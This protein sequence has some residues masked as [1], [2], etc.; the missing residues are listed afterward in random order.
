ME[1]QIPRERL[2][3]LVK[4]VERNLNQPNVV[5]VTL[6]F[7]AYLEAIAD[8]ITEQ[9]LPSASGWNHAKKL[10]VLRDYPLLDEP[11]FL[12]ACEFAKI[13]NALAHS[14]EDLTLG[15]AGIRPHYQT[16]TGIVSK[17]FDVDSFSRKVAEQVQEAAK[18]ILGIQKDQ[19]HGFSGLEGERLKASA[20]FLCIHFLSVRYALPAKNVPLPFSNSYRFRGI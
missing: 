3:A 14:F 11:A 7:G 2:D 16:F 1:I 6:A 8:E 10:R 5:L 18:T 17:A 9:I 12:A 20:F 19:H 15:D 4:L 13:R